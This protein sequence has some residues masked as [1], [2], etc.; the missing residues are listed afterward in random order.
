MATL[1]ALLNSARILRRCD[2]R[3]YDATTP[4]CKCICG[5]LNHGVGFRQ[6]VANCRAM[7]ADDIDL[8][9]GAPIAAEDAKPEHPKFLDLPP[10]NFLFPDAH[11]DPT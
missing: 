4:K 6:A 8:P 1:L 7:I 9:C 5:G 2:K 11:V 3:C 10:E